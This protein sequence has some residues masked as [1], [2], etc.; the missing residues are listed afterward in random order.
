MVSPAQRIRHKIG[1]IDAR[2][3]YLVSGAIAAGANSLSPIDADSRAVT[4]IAVI[5]VIVVRQFRTSAAR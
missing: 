3:F 5:I 1:S 2:L 4:I